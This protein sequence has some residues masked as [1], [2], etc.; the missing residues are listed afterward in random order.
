MEDER[1]SRQRRVGKHAISDLKRRAQK[2][3]SEH[4]GPV[5]IGDEWVHLKSND[6]IEIWTRTP[7]VEERLAAVDADLGAPIREPTPPRPRS[8][9]ARRLTK[10][11]GNQEGIK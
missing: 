8:A 3:D 6:A 7:T 1:R 5:P 2:L 4:R 10:L 9:A 11:F